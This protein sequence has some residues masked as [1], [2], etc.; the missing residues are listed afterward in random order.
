VGQVAELR[1]PSERQVQPVEIVIIDAREL[2]ARL[3]LP[4]SWV[5]EACRSRCDDPIPHLVFG[6][7]RR[8]RWGSPELTAWLARRAN[9]KA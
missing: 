7:Y 9:G 1:R 4:V 3:K 2:A 5:Q 6:K 8:F